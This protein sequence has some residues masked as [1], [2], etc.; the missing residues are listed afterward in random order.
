MASRTLPVTANPTEYS[1]VRPRLLPCSVSQSSSP[2]GGTGAVG[3][4]QHVFAVGGRDLGNGTGK[5]VDVV[6]DGVGAG[7]ARTHYHREHRLGRSQPVNDPGSYT[8]HRDHL[9]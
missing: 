4:D 6:G 3:A 7:V 9:I 8:T 1:M 2:V 5:Y